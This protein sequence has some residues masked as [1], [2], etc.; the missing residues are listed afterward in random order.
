MIGFWGKNMIFLKQFISILL[1][2]FWVSRKVIIAFLLSLCVA[3]SPTIIL[4]QTTPQELVQEGKAF[5]EVGNLPEAIASLQEAVDLFRSANEQENLAVTL[6]NLGNIQLT[7][8]QANE[9]LE[10]WQQAQTIYQDLG[11]NSHVSLSQINQSRALQALGL[12]PR[13]CN[14]LIQAFQLAP[15][16]CN[17]LTG[18]NLQR[19]RSDRLPVV[20]QVAGLR[21][22]GNLFRGMGKLEES[23]LVLAQAVTQATSLSPQTKG[24]TQL[25]LA[26]TLRARGNLER[27]RLSK[28]EYQHLPWR[29][30]PKN[31]PEEAETYYQQADSKYL[32]LSKDASLP[33]E[34]KIRAQLNHLSLLLERGKQTQTQDLDINVE[35]LPL[36]R[37]KVYAR[38]NYAKSL[39]FL[40][41]QSSRVSQSKELKVGSGKQEKGNRVSWETVTNLL[42]I[43]LNEAQE[44]EDSYAQ[45]YALGNLGS[46][47]EYFATIAQKPTESQQWNKQAQQ[48][49]EEAL[50]ILQ[51]QVN[52]EAAYQWQWQ[53]G[54]LLASQGERDG[55]I[56][57]YESAAQTL[58][59]VR[60]NLITINSDV[61]FSF[62]DNVEP[63][64]RELVSLL[65]PKGETN[66]PQEN[67]KKS[68][69]Y[70]EALQLAELENFLRCTVQNQNNEGLLAGETDN[71]QAQTELL[72][73]RINRVIQDD[74]NQKTAF[75]Y[76]I[77]LPEQVAV[78]LKLPNQ[79]KLAY[80][81]TPKN[82]DE[83]EKVVNKATLSLKIK[84]DIDPN[85]EQ[86]LKDLYQILLA[87]SIPDLEQAQ[88]KTLIF[89]LDNVF[90]PIPMSA[91]HNGQNY[92]VAQDYA[93]VVVPT[94][95]LL[96][97]LS[98]QPQ[99]LTALIGGAIKHRDGFNPLEENVKSQIA[100][101]KKLLP[102][103]KIISD[104]SFTKA[105][106]QQELAANYYPILHLVTHGKFASDPQETF[107]MT[108]D[109]GKDFEDYSLNINEFENLLQTGKQNQ[110]IELLVLSAC[111]SAEGDNRAVLGIAGVAVKSGAKATVA[112]LWT[113]DQDSS[114][115]L[116]EKFYE[117]LTTKEVSK[118]K[119]LN[120]AQ[121]YVLQ[122][123][124]HISPY[125]WAPFVLVGN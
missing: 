51:P 34:L 66:L 71:Q 98:F 97:P 50:L 115:L 88:A 100:A 85:E 110:A 60:R 31:T 36:S 86:P 89:I 101:L 58:D 78:I 7:L 39:A 26:N 116:V 35:N 94:V 11:N 21:S 57:T 95:Q 4:A 75:L 123:S 8:G 42:N 63:L 119:A 1:R 64:Y 56:T 77:L 48:L 92:L 96:Q 17:N 38:I 13:A 10:T 65:L 3:L 106:I 27:D 72:I 99:Q 52:P 80:H 74:P 44:L 69:Y 114:N 76:P 120:L 46:L 117:N 30:T 16:N 107:I 124:N 43:A 41:Q 6:T 14:T 125:H 79:E 113:V 20:V 111:D 22:L 93:T 121:R 103:S 33:A 49:T 12:Y 122:Q 90:R 73:K 105:T 84:A 82:K 112:P 83:V 2:E 53:L 118:A 15:L 23:E 28:S 19:L 18:E 40:Q 61:Q 59:Q 45:A 109:E 37:N 32:A 9:A 67:L 91:L 81:L 102:N 62:R 104:G 25:S 54:R 5:Y 70:V 29:Y 108:D 24:A 55:A 68:L 87:N 47:D